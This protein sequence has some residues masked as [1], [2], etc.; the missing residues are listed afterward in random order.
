M[1]DGPMSNITYPG[2]N[3]SPDNYTAELTQIAA[4]LKV[5]AAKVGAKLV[6]AQT[7]EYMCSATSDGC[8]QNLNNQAAA[9]MAAAGIPVVG[10]W[11]A[12]HAKCGD[13]PTTCGNAFNMTNGLFCPHV[14]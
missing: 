3:N 14:R 10:T 9:V 2:Q 13:A 8:V 1:H 12:M 11:D 7:T 4:R 5:Y 6:F